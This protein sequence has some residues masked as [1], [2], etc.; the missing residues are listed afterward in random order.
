MF[1]PSYHGRDPLRHWA[2]AHQNGVWRC[3]RMQQPV[4]ML[5]DVFDKSAQCTD[6]AR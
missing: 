1:G 5:S 3:T 6:I 2:F 4:W